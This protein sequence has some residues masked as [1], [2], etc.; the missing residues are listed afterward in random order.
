MS[1]ESNLGLA[2]FEGQKWQE[3]STQ[4]RVQ[5]NEALTKLDRIGRAGAGDDSMDGSADGH[6]FVYLCK[7]RPDNGDESKAC[8]EVF[9][10]IS[11]SS[12]FLFFSR[13]WHLIIA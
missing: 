8:R 2:E 5:L 7:W 6:E 3:E 9:G 13:I 10:T 1:K 4:L 12:F 11:V